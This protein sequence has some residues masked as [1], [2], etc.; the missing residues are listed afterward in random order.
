VGKSNAEKNSA[1]AL[2]EFLAYKEPT[3]FMQAYIDVPCLGRINF[4]VMTNHGL[5]DGR[6]YGMNESGR[7]LLVAGFFSEMYC[8]LQLWG[9][10]RISLAMMY[11]HSKINKSLFHACSCLILLFLGIY[12][13]LYATLHTSIDLQHSC[14]RGENLM[15]T[16][17]H[18]IFIN[19]V[20]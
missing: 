3:L 13:F 15:R 4:Y 16:P 19:Q 7:A 5:M 20:Q 12:C 14:H 6:M 8:T 11:A 10:W 17:I 1:S 9:R 2:K 18:V